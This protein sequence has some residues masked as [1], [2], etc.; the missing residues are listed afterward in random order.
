MKRRRGVEPPGNYILQILTHRLRQY[1][2]SKGVVVQCK[3]HKTLE[4]R[5]PCIHSD[6]P[7]R[8]QKVFKRALIE[9]LCYAE[10]E[11]NRE[12]ECNSLKQ[13]RT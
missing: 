13:Q 10:Q 2:M 1:L 7:G 6:F 5:A 4:S 3:P 12:D 11:Y 8:C 9:Q